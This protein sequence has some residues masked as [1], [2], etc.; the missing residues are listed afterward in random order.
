MTD[1]NFEWI[2]GAE[3]ELVRTLDS[4]GGTHGITAFR[5]IGYVYLDGRPDGTSISN[6]LIHPDLLEFNSFCFITGIEGR[7]DGD[8]EMVRIFLKDIP[9]S[10][11]KAWHYSFT[12][13]K[14]DVRVWLT[15]M[16]LRELV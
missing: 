1:A 10:I 3:K 13:G 12:S 4:R 11:H 7:W 14:A 6:Q 9:S 5:P 15:V 8:S 16:G 2:D